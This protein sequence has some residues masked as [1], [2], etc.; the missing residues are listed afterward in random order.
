MIDFF[1]T[2]I[3]AKRFVYK[4]YSLLGTAPILY[5]ICQNS[6]V[7]FFSIQAKDLKQFTEIS[8]GQIYNLNKYYCMRKINLF[9]DNKKHF[10]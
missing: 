8:K 6:M 3:F 10:L 5:S 7:V 4:L 2:F 1:S 9:S